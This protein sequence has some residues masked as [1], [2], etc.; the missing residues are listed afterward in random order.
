L[1]V[2]G[3]MKNEA[4]QSGKEIPAKKKAVLRP[5]RARRVS[6]PLESRYSTIP[7]M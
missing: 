5:L 6:T 4:T 3:M 1:D 7:A 2:S